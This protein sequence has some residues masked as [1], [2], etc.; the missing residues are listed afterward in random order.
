MR[1]RSVLKSYARKD[2]GTVTVDFVVLNAALLALG[3]AVLSSVARG[4]MD[5]S[6]A[7]ANHIEAVE[8]GVGGQG[9]QG[10]GVGSSEGDQEGDGHSG[11]S[12]GGDTGGDTGTDAGS[13][14]SGGQG[15]PGNDR[16]VGRAGETPNGQDGW[17]SGSQGRS[18]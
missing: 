14:S 2:D 4:G 18:S 10:E 16:D 5:F 17:G 11:A 7:L 6:D 15:N 13:G 12:N 3:I 1:L 8:T 9:S